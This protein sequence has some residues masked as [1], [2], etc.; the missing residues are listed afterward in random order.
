MKEEEILVKVFNGNVYFN[1]TLH[2]MVRVSTTPKTKRIKILEWKLKK[3][4]IVFEIVNI[5]FVYA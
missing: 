2:P 4:K 3:I 1:K 5:Y